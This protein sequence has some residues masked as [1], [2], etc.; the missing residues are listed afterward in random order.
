VCAGFQV[1]G[2]SFADAEGRR[3]EGIGLIDVTTAKGSAKRCVGELVSEPEERVLTSVPQETLTGFENHS[4]LTS[5]G[6]GIRPLGRVL[7]GVGNGDGS[8]AEGAISGRFVGTYMHGPVLARNPALADALLSMAT[9]QSLAPLDDT[10]EE[11]LRSERFLAVGR[12][13]Q[14]GFTKR[15]ADLARLVRQRTS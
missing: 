2:D 5:L 13:G 9:G 10:E 8:H 14:S 11:S 12:G 7:A 3:C 15:A 1:V 6:A 4:G